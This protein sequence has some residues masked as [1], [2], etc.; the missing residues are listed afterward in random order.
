MSGVSVRTLHFYDEAE[1]LSRDFQT[2]THAE[3]LDK[4]L[5]AVKSLVQRYGNRKMVILLQEQTV[6]PTDQVISSGV[7]AGP[8]SISA[9]KMR[10]HGSATRGSSELSWR[11]KTAIAPRPYRLP[12]K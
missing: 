9:L 6:S 5:A 8:Y 11:S 2:I 3:D 1:L 7:M 10:N 12:V 4:D